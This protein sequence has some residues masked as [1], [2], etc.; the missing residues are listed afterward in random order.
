MLD[1]IK[2]GFYNFF[3]APQF[4]TTN[5]GQ[6]VFERPLTQPVTSVY[7][8]AGIPVQRIMYTER[9]AQVIPNRTA[10]VNSILGNGDTYAGLLDLSQLSQNSATNTSM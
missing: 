8:S 6:E 2:S 5:M 9:P 10:V 3:R 1:K 4:N 7:G